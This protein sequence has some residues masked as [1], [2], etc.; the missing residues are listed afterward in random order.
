MPITLRGPRIALLA[1]AVLP[2]LF[3]QQQSQPPSVFI[4][5]TCI[6]SQ[7]GKSQ[8][9]QKYLADVSKKVAQVRVNE[10]RIDWWAVE[11]AVV[12]AGEAAR[13]EY[14]IITAHTGSLPEPPNAAE[15]AADYE[16]AKI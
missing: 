10:G 7:D 13:C 16:R 6:K 4:W 8:D 15:T 2:A 14:H 12:P 3:A 1:L 5:D 9:L 11:R